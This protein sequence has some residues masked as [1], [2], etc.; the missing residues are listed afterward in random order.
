MN[1]IQCAACSGFTVRHRPDSLCGMLRIMQ[2]RSPHVL[3]LFTMSKGTFGWAWL[4][5]RFWVAK[6]HKPDFLFH[7]NLLYISIEKL[8]EASGLVG[9][10]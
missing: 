10:Q 1:R 2:K 8:D 5:I 9:R 6:H 3:S 4:T 7:P